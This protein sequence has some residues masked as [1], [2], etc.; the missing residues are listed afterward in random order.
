MESHYVIITATHNFIINNCLH[1]ECF[2]IFHLLDAQLNQK[3]YETYQQ[4][5]TKVNLFGFDGT[6]DCFVDE[7]HV[8]PKYKISI[9]ISMTS[10][11]IYKGYWKLSLKQFIFYY[12]NIFSYIYDLEKQNVGDWYFQPCAHTVYWY[13]HYLRAVHHQWHQHCWGKLY[14]TCQILKVWRTILF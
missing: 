13:Q 2:L 12:L 4:F 6:D 5:F 10:L 14:Q 8:W 3:H 11:F 7:T 9:L 1:S